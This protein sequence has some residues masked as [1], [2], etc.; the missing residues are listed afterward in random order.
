MLRRLQTDDEPV[1]RFGPYLFA[2][3]RHESFKVMKRR[4]RAD[5]M[6]DTPEEEAARECPPPI[7]TD[8]ER[9]ALLESSQDEVRA[10]NARL[11][12]RYREVLA[13]RELEGCSYDEIAEIL[14]TNRNAV[15]QL[16]W[17]ARSKLRDELRL[18]GV[19]SVAAASADCERAQALLSIEE[20]GE[21]GE[22]DRAWLER[23]LRT[24]GNCRTSRAALLEVG[25]SYRS[26]L[27]IAALAGMR[28]HVL[29]RGGELVGAN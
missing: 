24:C 15:S 2:A 20:D 7:E 16:I 3:A 19:Y 22:L 12:L 5:L 27:P 26:W 29:S 25:A 18:G 1:L 4:G 28:E 17:R 14:G 8:P 9:S 10:A 21:L 11:P 23:H 6:E 13:L